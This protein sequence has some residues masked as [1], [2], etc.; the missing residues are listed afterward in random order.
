MSKHYEFIHKKV[1][2]ICNCIFGNIKTKTDAKETILL[3]IA[4]S[5]KLYESDNNF[6]NKINETERYIKLKMKLEKL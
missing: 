1:I 6:R 2:D 4:T 3:M 5:C